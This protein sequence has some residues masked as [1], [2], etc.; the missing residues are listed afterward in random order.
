MHRKE[1][2]RVEVQAKTAGVARQGVRTSG[3][4]REVAKSSGSKGPGK[5]WPSRRRR[6]EACHG[7]S[8]RL[9]RGSLKK[10]KKKGN[11]STGQGGKGR[12]WYGKNQRGDHQRSAVGRTAWGCH[13]SRNFWLEETD[14]AASQNRVKVDEDDG[15]GEQKRSLVLAPGTGSHWESSAVQGTGVLN[16]RGEA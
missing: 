15:I 8:S 9:R 5:A 11:G 3:G 7:G 1:G 2:K 4:G 13:R 16:V 14:L 12:G 10:A 6:A